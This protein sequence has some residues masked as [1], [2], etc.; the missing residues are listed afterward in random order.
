[1]LTLVALLMNVLL[2][3]TVMLMDA[4]VLD[5]SSGTCRGEKGA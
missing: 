2:P 1:M 4:T 3:L 5:G